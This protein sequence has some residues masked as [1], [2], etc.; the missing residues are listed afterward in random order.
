MNFGSLKDF[1]S[2]KYN[3]DS[4]NIF[5][6]PNQSPRVKQFEKLSTKMKIY[7]PKKNK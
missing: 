3:P 5:S 1:L 6:Q 7:Q 4:K 2:Q